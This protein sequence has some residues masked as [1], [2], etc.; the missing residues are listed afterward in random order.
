MPQTTTE[1]FEQLAEREHEPLLAKVNG[2]LRFDLKD[3]GKTARW[4]VAIAVAGVAGLA[5]AIPR[6]W[7]TTPSVAP[8]PSGAVAGPATPAR[9]PTTA[10][11]PV[12][13]AAAPPVPSLPPRTAS[14]TSASASIS[15]SPAKPAQAGTAETE[16]RPPQPT[17]KTRR[18]TRRHRLPNLDQHGIG[19]PSE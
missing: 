4:R 17:D 10:A 2:T 19:I 18:A 12:R 15:P 8:A 11:A 5:V 14:G 13:P 1:F 6:A 3:N 7:R 9:P 16:A